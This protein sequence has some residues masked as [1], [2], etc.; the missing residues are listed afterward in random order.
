LEDLD[1]KESSL[2]ASLA[3]VAHQLIKAAAPS[4]CD[5]LPK[6]I[7]DRFPDGF[8]ERVAKAHGELARI[9]HTPTLQLAKDNDVPP[10]TAHRWVKEAR[11]RGLLGRGAESS[12]GGREPLTPEEMLFFFDDSVRISDVDRVIEDATRGRSMSPHAREGS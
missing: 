11:R 7:G 9:S 5:F 6:I 1:R 8:F 12:Y 2:A 4:A 10:S 3:Q